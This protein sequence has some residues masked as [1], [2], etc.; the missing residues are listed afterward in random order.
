MLRSL[1]LD[2]EVHPW[3]WGKS[4]AGAE[5]RARWLRPPL[6]YQ[7]EA[8]D[9]KVLRTRR[10][11]TAPVPSPLP[12]PMDGEKLPA[13]LTSSS[14]AH[15]MK[16]CAPRHVRV[17]SPSSLSTASL[18]G[19]CLRAG[20]LLTA[21]PWLASLGTEPGLS[22]GAP[23]RPQ[24]AYV[25]PVSM[26][27]CFG[28]GSCFSKH[29]R[30]WWLR[31]VGRWER[32]LDG[33]GVFVAAAAGA[34]AVAVAAG[35][36]VGAA[37]GVTVGAA[38]GAADAAVGSKGLVPLHV[39]GGVPPSAKALSPGI[40]RQR[41]PHL[42][43][44]LQ[45]EVVLALPP[46][47]VARCRD[48]WEL[49]VLVH[50]FVTAALLLGLV[51]QMPAVPCRL[52]QGWAD[53]R[54]NRSASDSGR[55]PP[56]LRPFTF[57]LGRR[58]GIGMGD[59]LATGPKRSPRCLLFPGGASCGFDLIDHAIE[60]NT[61]GAGPGSS[62][63]AAGAAAQGSDARA[64]AASD[65]AVQLPAGLEAIA[66]PTDRLVALCDGSRAHLHSLLRR[67]NAARVITLQGLD[68]RSAFI[69]DRAPS[70]LS[71]AQLLDLGSAP[72]SLPRVGP[73][74]RSQCPG[75]A[76]YLR[77]LRECEHTFLRTAAVIER[78]KLAGDLKRQEP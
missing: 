19:R 9:D 21:P 69:I 68:P 2:R 35:G 36:A 16:L 56:I 31:A 22:W 71:A 32:K 3:N 64:R 30:V 18:S 7:R 66:S 24:I 11:L 47:T 5:P 53:G 50:N 77:A 39:P 4:A 61:P 51:P 73:R 46:A 78:S 49:H 60:G 59:V 74:L 6:A 26:W 57:V 13:H 37:V 70:K 63:E 44:R 15:S 33:P 29:N 40:L 55:P 62:G 41:M 42:L 27:R 14:A 54:L 20:R 72:D 23:P 12:P 1:E 45:G 48:F 43:E 34:G 38:V 10:R 75:A 65:D 76:R 8:Y 28:R 52:F 58:Y 25:H 67:P 17:S